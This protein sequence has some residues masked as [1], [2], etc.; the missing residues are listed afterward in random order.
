MNIHLKIERLVLEGLS[1]DK[2]QGPQIQAA[3]EA[4]LARL[5]GASGLSEELR[6]GTALPRVPAGTIQPPHHGDPALLGRQIA[7]AVFG[8]IGAPTT[9]KAQAP[10]STVQ[11]E[12]R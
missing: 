6:Q 12:P 3:V 10:K 7:N 9:G 11:G 5:L 4:E 2:R 1:V 8:G